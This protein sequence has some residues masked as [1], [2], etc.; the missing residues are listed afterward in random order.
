MSLKGV[1]NSDK[2]KRKIESRIYW[3]II[4]YL[5]KHYFMH[6]RYAWSPSGVWKA[7]KQRRDKERVKKR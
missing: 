6:F 1:Y 7:S 4:L 3:W 2:K 5:E